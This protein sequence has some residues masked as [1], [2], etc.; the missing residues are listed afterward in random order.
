MTQTVSLWYYLLGTCFYVLM[1]G[2]GAIAQLASCVRYWG[3]G[4][5]TAGLS[6]LLRVLRRPQV[7]FVSRATVVMVRQGIHLC[8]C[9][10]LPLFMFVCPTRRRLLMN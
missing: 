10:Y 3:F 7:V 1:C 9:V 8:Q 2:T 4:V 6:F 5:Q